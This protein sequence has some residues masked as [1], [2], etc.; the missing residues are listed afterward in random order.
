MSLG[1]VNGDGQLEILVLPRVP[2]RLRLKLLTPVVKA[3][4]AQGALVAT[5]SV[6]DPRFSG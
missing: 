5:L 2:A 3:F 4:S 6:N 1:D